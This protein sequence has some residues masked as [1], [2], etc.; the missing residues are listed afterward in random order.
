MPDLDDLTPEDR[1]ETPSPAERRARERRM[2]RAEGR[3]G[4]PRSWATAALGLLALIFCYWLV[5]HTP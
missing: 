2:A 4:R 3:W 1:G 5:T